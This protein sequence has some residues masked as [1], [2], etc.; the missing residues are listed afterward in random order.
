MAVE[1]E[2]GLSLK[3]RKDSRIESVKQDLGW[4]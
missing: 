4:S 1:A 2:S 3:D